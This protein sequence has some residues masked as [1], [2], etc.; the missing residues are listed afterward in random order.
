MFCSER[1]SSIIVSRFSD[2]PN[3]LKLSILEVV[4][5]EKTSFARRGINGATNEVITFLIMF[6]FIFNEVEDCS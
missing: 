2:T 5:L 4:S 1:V 3:S 6:S